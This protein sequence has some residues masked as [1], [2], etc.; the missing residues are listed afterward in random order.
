MNQ[1]IA[2]SIQSLNAYFDK[3]ELKPAKENL[4]PKL[5][6]LY[7]NITDELVEFYE[8]CD[9]FHSGFEE[10]N[11]IILGVESIIELTEGR[12]GE[13]PLFTQLL[14]IRNDGC[15]NFDC[16]VLGPTG[17]NTIVFWDRETS[18]K[19]DYP[20]AGNLDNFFDFFVKWAITCYHHDGTP[21]YEYDIL[22]NCDAQSFP[23]PF[24]LNWIIQ[25]D[26]TLK[27]WLLSTE[28]RLLFDQELSTK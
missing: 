6:A 19:P 7:P 12:S 28:Y 15:W 21:K 10:E 20:I 1:S 23:W 22:E 18:E 26:Q 4:I 17:K 8:C 2:N 25:N 24:E 3:F 13:N 9:G 16:V 5:K 14:P 27:E 11:S